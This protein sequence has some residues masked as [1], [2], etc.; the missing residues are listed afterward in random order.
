MI[1]YLGVEVE[2][3][4]TSE[5]AGRWKD[6]EAMC[7]QSKM[8]NVVYIGVKNVDML[9]SSTG[10]EYALGNMANILA[11]SSQDTRCEPRA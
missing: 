9:S 6:G 5:Q 7:K 8:L 3:P 4:T 2:W 1:Y 11:T 10:L